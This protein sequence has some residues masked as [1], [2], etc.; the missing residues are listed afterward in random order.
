MNTVTSLLMLLPWLVLMAFWLRNTI[1]LHRLMS[2][3]E[4]LRHCNAEL[5]AALNRGD[6]EAAERWN[7]RFQEIHEHVKPMMK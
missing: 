5:E 6:L 7:E 3:S 4:D 2:L 1:R